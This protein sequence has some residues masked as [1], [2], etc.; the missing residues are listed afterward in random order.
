M[1]APN[2]PSLS[3]RRPPSQLGHL[4]G[5]TPSAR[6]GKICGASISSRASITSA[7]RR[8]FM[9]STARAKSRQ[10]VGQRP[11]R[12][13][14]VL[15]Q[16]VELLSKTRREVL[17]DVGGEKVPQERAPAPPLVLGHEPLLVDAYVAAIL[18]HLQDR[19]VGR[20]PAD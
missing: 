5:S 2:L 13:S 7:T 9:S 14:F 12:R 19:R 18:E 20:G 1:K 10:D 16:G 17:F 11:A 15:E 3:E 4:R 6:G 8:S